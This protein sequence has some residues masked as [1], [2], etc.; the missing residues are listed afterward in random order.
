M[1]R[2]RQALCGYVDYAN[3]LHYN[4]YCRFMRSGACTSKHKGQIGQ[5]R[6]YELAGIIGDLSSTREAFIASNR[7][8]G[9]LMYQMS[10]ASIAV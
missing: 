6:W 8:I 2:Q 7:I 5:H 9:A 3:K 10:A 1:E 4:A